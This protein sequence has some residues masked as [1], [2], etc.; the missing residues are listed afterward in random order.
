MSEL[1]LTVSWN[2]EDWHASDR[3]GHAMQ[4]SRADEQW[5]P[6]LPEACICEQLLLPIEALLSRTFRL[7]LTHPR[8][9]DDGILGQDLDDRAGIEPDDWWLAWHAVKAMSVHDAEHHALSVQVFGMVFGMPVAWKQA[10]ECSPAWRQVQFAGVDAW[11]RLRRRLAEI[12]LPDTEPVPVAVFDTDREGVFFGLWQGGGWLGMRRINRAGREAKAMAEE[13][14]RSLSAMAGDTGSSYNTVGL[15]DEELLRMLNLSDWKGMARQPEDL[16]GRHAA[17]LECMVL[18]SVTADMVNFRHGRWVAVSGLSWLN[19]WK[20]AIA[21]AVLLLTVWL[22]GTALQNN[23]LD[24]QAAAYQQQII[25]A[26]H[27]GLPGEMV[28]LDPLAQLR[29]ATGASSSAEAFGP[30]FPQQLAAISRAYSNIPWN[31]RE[32]EWRDGRVRI[33]G[34]AASLQALNRVRQALQKQ[35]GTDVKLLD[36]DLS[37]RE[38]SFRMQWP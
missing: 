38:V 7:P 12:A 31:M 36:T 15:L 18:L 20:R 2:G 32:L 26:F 6:E 27:Q 17:N 23:S 8:L 16:P 24:R 3:A 33:S 28:M 37:G 25:D 14:R 5:L 35:T 4:L 30:G 9:I 13:I 10:M 11:V 21:L 1:G 34:K 22:I 29:R 19:P